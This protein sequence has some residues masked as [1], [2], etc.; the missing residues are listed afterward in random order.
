MAVTGLL[1]VFTAAKGAILPAPVA[2]NPIPGVSFTQLKPLAVP[3][4]FIAVVFDPLLTVCELTAFTVGG[5]FTVPVTVTL[6]PVAP[7]EL[8]VTGPDI[9]PGDAV[10]AEHT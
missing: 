7:A 5:A 10:A 9:L 6:W 1:P 4:K 3:V 2:V 8:N